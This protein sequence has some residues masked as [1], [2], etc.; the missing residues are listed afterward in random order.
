M[1]IS[2]VDTAIYQVGLMKKAIVFTALVFFSTLWED[3]CFAQN[4]KSTFAVGDIAP[5]FEGKDQFGQAFELSRVLKNNPVVLMFYR[6]HWCPYCN[7]QLSQLE[8]SINFITDKGGIVV[9]VTPE[10]PEG[11]DKTMKKTG[12]SFLILHDKNLEIMKK[13]GVDFRLEDDLMKKYLKMG[14]TNGAN[15]AN[16]PVPATYIINSDQKILYSFYDPDYKKR[17]TVKKI[18]ENL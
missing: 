11:I 5:N 3:P 18:L 4:N 10:Q 1:Y 15:G 14:M 17:A 16:L 13:Y 12:A 6:G 7:K 9:A 2:K 8:D